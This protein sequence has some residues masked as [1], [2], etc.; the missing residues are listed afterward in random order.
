[1]PWSPA[2][3]TARRPFV[4]VCVCI[5]Q[6]LASSDVLHVGALTLHRLHLSTPLPPDLIHQAC[7]ALHEVLIYK[8]IYICRP[9]SYEGDGGG[10]RVQVQRTGLTWRGPCSVGAWTPN[11]W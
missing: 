8:H 5:P 10:S 9:F 4:Y 11:R 1:M 3:H 6:A 7:T 2:P